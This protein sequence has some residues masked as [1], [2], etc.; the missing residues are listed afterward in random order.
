MLRDSLSFLFG[1]PSLMDSFAFGFGPVKRTSGNLAI[2]SKNWFSG[3]P[4]TTEPKSFSPEGDSMR[5][6][7]L[8]AIFLL[9]SKKIRGSRGQG[10][11]ARRKQSRT[12]KLTDD[13][14]SLQPGF[15]GMFSHRWARFGP[16]YNHR[17][18]TVPTRLFEPR[19]YIGREC[20]RH[21]SVAPCSEEIGRTLA[22]PAAKLH[23]ELL[24]WTRALH[25]AN[26][27]PRAGKVING[28]W[29]L[30]SAN[31][32]CVAS[33]NRL[34]RPCRLDAD[35]KHLTPASPILDF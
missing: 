27:N 33:T 3:I 15:S 5:S 20:C 10:C 30:G 14:R 32:T 34:G 26:P 6:S 23:F 18:R 29:Q 19:S 35:S 24:F 9:K 25:C 21:K 1:M 31:S 12:L 16:G 11:V 7:I 4:N 22:R 13:S 2:N 28:Y 17:P 8:W